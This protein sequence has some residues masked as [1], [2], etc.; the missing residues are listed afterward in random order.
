MEYRKLGSSELKVSVLSLGAWQLS[1]TGYWGKSPEVDSDAAVKLITA[2]VAELAKSPGI[3]RS[4]AMRRAIAKLITD[5]SRPSTWVSAAHPAVW[6]PF[7]V[8]GEGGAGR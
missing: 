2:A 1:D 8:V 4:E 7:A 3:G 5:P 6:A